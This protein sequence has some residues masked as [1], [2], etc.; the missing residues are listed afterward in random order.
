MGQQQ[1]VGMGGVRHQRVDRVANGNPQAAFGNALQPFAALRGVG[2]QLR[3][4]GTG[5][6]S[7]VAQRVRDGVVTQLLGHQ[8]PGH[9]VHAQPAEGFGHRQRGQALLG[10]FVAQIRR[11]ADVGL[12]DFT[13]H[14]RC[15]FGHQE[16]ADGFAEGLLV[17]GKGKVHT[18]PH[19]GRPSMRSAMMLR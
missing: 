2:C 9:I 6:I 5:D 11:A 7:G 8:S 16:T 12:P 3:N 17:I 19:F 1:Q 10:N 4:Q 18:R 15:G 13:K 14:F